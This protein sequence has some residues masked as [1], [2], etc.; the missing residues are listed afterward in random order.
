MK[1]PKNPELIPLNPGIKNIGKSRP[2]KS[3]D[4]RIL[5]YPVP[6]I[7]GLKIL[8]PAGAWLVMMMMVMIYSPPKCDLLLPPLVDVSSVVVSTITARNSHL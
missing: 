5:Q 3:R 6:K 2:E 8:D 7:P 1:I 4:P